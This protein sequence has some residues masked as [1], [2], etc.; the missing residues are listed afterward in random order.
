MAAWSLLLP[1]L[2]RLVPLRRLAALMW[3]SGTIERSPERERAIILFSARVTRRRANCLE[4]SLLAYRFL[5]RAG[6]DPHLVVGVTNVDGVIAGHAWVTVDGVPVHDP[7]EGL[8]RFAPL[9]LFA[10]GE[11]VE[12]SDA[13]DPAELR[14]WW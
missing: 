7:L 9:V 6:A 14:I 2:K 11:A 1:A 10:H 3:R 12:L 5:A 13:A 8:D 4:R